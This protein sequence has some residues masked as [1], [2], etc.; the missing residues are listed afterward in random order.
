MEQVAVAL[1]PVPA[2]PAAAQAYE[3]GWAR[4]ST[5]APSAAGEAPQARAPSAAAV[6]AP[7]PDDPTLKR[8]SVLEES[9]TH[10]TAML[11]KVL[12]A[13]QAARRGASSPA[14]AAAGSAPP[15]ALRRESHD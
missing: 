11:Q 5:N 13:R 3:D 12:L 2:A 4:P 14:L 9:V 8:L 15:R 7:A 6:V 1:A 10:C